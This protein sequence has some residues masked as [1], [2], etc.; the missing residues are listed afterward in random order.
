MIDLN[1]PDNS[2][3][4][5][6]APYIKLWRGV[7][8][9]ATR[10]GCLSSQAAYNNYLWMQGSYSETICERA[11]ID[12]GL[13][14][15]FYKRL[16]ESADLRSETLVKMRGFKS[17]FITNVGGNKGNGNNQVQTELLF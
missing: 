6:F 8:I 5:V 13:I 10:D 11:N 4:E 15:A 17:K 2:D 16:N 12:H 3:N 7:I 9:N 14:L 1:S